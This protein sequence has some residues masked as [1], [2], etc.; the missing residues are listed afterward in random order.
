M[1]TSTPGGAITMGGNSATVITYRRLLFFLTRNI[2][3]R[4]YL[5]FRVEDGKRQS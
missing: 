1:R 5:I 4:R 3:G 2:F